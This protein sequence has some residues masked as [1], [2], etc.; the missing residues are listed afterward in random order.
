MG[1]RTNR[2]WRVSRPEGDIV[3]K[4]YDTETRNPLFPNDPVSEIQMLHHLAEH[5]IAP[6][7]LDHFPTE[8]G[9][10]LVYAHLEGPSWRTGTARVATLL[11]RLHNIAPPHGLRATA[12]GSNELRSEALSILDG[13]PADRALELR[14]LEPTRHVPASGL[15]RLLHADPVPANMIDHAG[16]LKL[17][18]W[19]CPAVGDPCEDIAVFLSPAM[20][21]IYRGTILTDVEKDTFL[22]AYPDGG[23]IRRYR[24]LEPWYQWRM[25]AYCL[26]KEARGDEHAKYAYDAEINALKA[27]LSEQL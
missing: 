18:D 6:H 26:W 12:D 5:Y 19:Q 16:D 7:L 15:L 27:A 25:A 9:V 2:L 24:Q 3:V 13:C 11:H 8:M 23:T 22:K 21:L 17:I 10:C 1:G 4:L 14:S 20:H